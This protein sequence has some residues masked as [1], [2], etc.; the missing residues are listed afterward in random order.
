MSGF[1]YNPYAR[2][3]MQYARRWAR[4]QNRQ[5]KPF[6]LPDFVVKS[7]IRV[8]LYVNSVVGKTDET[9]WCGLT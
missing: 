9:D 4:I 3:L 2:S 8:N 7:Q 5:K 6:F 1:G